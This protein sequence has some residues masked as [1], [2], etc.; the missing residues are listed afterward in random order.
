MGHTFPPAARASILAW[1]DAR[2][3]RFSFR[4]VKDPYAVLVCEIMAQQTQIER[5]AAKWSTFLARFPSVATLAGAPTAEVLREWRGLGYNR[6]ALNLQRA[7]QVIVSEHGGRVPSEIS[8][9]ERL[10]GV[11][12]YTARAVAALAFG[13][14]VGAVDTNVRRVL[15]RMVGGLAALPPRELQA[16]ADLAVAEHRPADWTHAVMD[17]G[18]NVCRARA[19]R[20][21]DCPGRRWCAFARIPDA[22]LARPAVARRPK[23]PYAATARW[24]RGRLMDR[25]RDAQGDEWTGLKAPIGV[26]DEEAIT[27]ALAQLAGEGL[28]E[29]DAASP[30]RARLPTAREFLAPGL[31]PVR[32]GN[33]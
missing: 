23:P 28:I 2:G 16:I 6:R 10:P 4:E 14:P 32:E 9:L 33:R 27:Q 3:R 22:A 8:A 31:G 21:G 24:L 7:A 5:A 29:L 18:A 20:C 15:R 26:H 30:L 25:L 11:G 13:Q 12:P 1:F 17:L 19:P